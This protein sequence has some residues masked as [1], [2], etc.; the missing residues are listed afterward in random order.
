MIRAKGIAGLIT[1]LLI[2]LAP[3]SSFS[4]TA[5]QEHLCFEGISDKTNFL[6]YPNTADPKREEIVG[7]AVDQLGFAL[8]RNEPL[9][10]MVTM[11]PDMASFYT[12]DKFSAS[13]KK[14]FPLL[15]RNSI[16]HIVHYG[17][18]S[19]LLLSGGSQL[20]FNHAKQTFIFSFDEPAPIA[21][22]AYY[23]G[24][25]MK[26]GKW[27][28]ALPASNCSLTRDGI[29]FIAAE[30]EHPLYNQSGSFCTYDGYYFKSAQNAVQV[31]KLDQIG[32][33]ESLLNENGLPAFLS[34]IR[35]E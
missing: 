5:T 17:D 10:T 34:W 33:G 4:A 16:E 25:G 26:P 30:R 8:D 29:T 9:K 2:L 7:K 21:G 28:G 20:L 22:L 12:Q 31:R 35:R 11:A 19:A 6:C 15:D 18:Y 27:T 23:Y 32:Q 3:F 1:L 13:L 14:H 24:R